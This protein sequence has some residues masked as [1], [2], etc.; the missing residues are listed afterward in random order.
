MR[1]ILISK[2]TQ[3]NFCSDAWKENKSRLLAYVLYLLL[4]ATKDVACRWQSETSGSISCG[5]SVQHTA[6]SRLIHLCAPRW[7][8]LRLSTWSAFCVEGQ[9]CMNRELPK[10]VSHVQRGF[11]AIYMHVQDADSRTLPALYVKHLWDRRRIILGSRFFSFLL[12]F[13]LTYS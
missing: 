6:T 12:G 1:L 10:S 4:D 9:L 2:I 3:Q 8:F 13:F 7:P 5:P 11:T